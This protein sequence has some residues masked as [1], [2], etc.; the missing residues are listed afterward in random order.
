MHKTVQR[1]CGS[2][3]CLGL[4]RVCVLSPAH[5]S[6]RAWASCKSRNPALFG[7]QARTQPCR[8]WR[9][10]EALALPCARCSDS[11][12]GLRVSC[13][14]PTPVETSSFPDK[15][16]ATRMHAVRSPHGRRPVRA[17]RF[18]RQRQRNPVVTFTAGRYHGRRRGPPKRH[19]T[20]WKQRIGR[21]PTCN[22]APFCRV[23]LQ[24]AHCLAGRGTC[25]F[26]RM[27]VAAAAAWLAARPRAPSAVLRRVAGSPPTTL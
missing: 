20:P 24:F 15:G 25:T 5:V 21:P 3:A 6:G 18:P 17:R 14:A 1:L 2:L 11:H 23:L 26:L 22:P 16:H 12:C 19:A 7:A 9:R 13:V 8:A 10:G 27:P 4:A